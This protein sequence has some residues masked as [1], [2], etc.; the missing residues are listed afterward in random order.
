[1]VVDSDTQ[2]TGT[3]SEPPVDSEPQADS[4]GSDAL[5]VVPSGDSGPADVVSTTPVITD[6]RSGRGKA[7]WSDEKTYRKNQNRLSLIRWPIGEEPYNVEA[8]HPDDPWVNVKLDV[9]ENPDL[10]PDQ[11][12]LLMGGPEIRM[13]CRHCNE[14]LHIAATKSALDILTGAS[15]TFND[16]DERVLALAAEGKVAACVCRNGHI[17]Q[18]RLEFAQR[19]IKDG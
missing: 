2:T 6:K 12:E 18:L 5:R 16:L 4:D 19:L 8:T 17:T 15:F 10:D 11:R 14:P 1:M 13:P 9:I 7:D 3:P